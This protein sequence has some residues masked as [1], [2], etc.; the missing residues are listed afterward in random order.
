[1]IKLKID[2]NMLRKKLNQ[3]LRR[4]SDL[5]PRLRRDRAQPL[6][7]IRAQL[8]AEGRYSSPDSWEG[9]S[10]HWDDL[11]ESTKA[12]RIRL[13]IPQA[14]VTQPHRHYCVFDVRGRRR[15]VPGIAVE[16]SGS[17]VLDAVPMAA[18]HYVL[19]SDS[20]RAEQRFQLTPD[21]R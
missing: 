4:S 13:G 17:L 9:G 8:S 3:H 1:M 7:V 20:H 12:P 10:R 19:G 16:R 2:H 18:G 21:N 5:S 6:L 14:E 11:A 15:V